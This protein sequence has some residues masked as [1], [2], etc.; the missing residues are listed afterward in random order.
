M[1]FNFAEKIKKGLQFF[2]IFCFFTVILKGKAISYQFNQ[3]KRGKGKTEIVKQKIL[4][5]LFA[6]KN[7]LSHRVNNLTSRVLDK[8][9]LPQMLS[10]LQVHS[11]YHRNHLKNQRYLLHLQMNIYQKK[12][13]VPFEQRYRGHP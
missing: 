2:F 1:I 7:K 13:T 8:T 12:V 4:Y 3:L 9:F 5:F 6:M 11:L 10:Y